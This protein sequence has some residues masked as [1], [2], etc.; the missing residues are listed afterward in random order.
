M[1]FGVPVG[2]HVLHVEADI[3]DIGVISQRPY[4]FIREGADPKAFESVTKFKKERNLDTLTQVKYKSPIGIDVRPFWGDDEQCEVGI[5]REDVDLQYNV[6]P[7]AIFMGSIF[8]NNEKD[9]VSRRCTPR[10]DVGRMCETVSTEGTVEMIRKTPS[11]GIERFDV[12]G[13]RVITENG[14]WAYQVPMNLDYVV[15]DEFGNIVPSDDPNKGIPTRARVR[16]RI[17]M[18]VT[19]GEGRLRTRAK[20][21]VPHNPNN[22]ADQDYSFDE[23]TDDNHFRDLYWNKIY[24]VRNYIARFQPVRGDDIRRMIG[25][26]DVDDCGDKTP[27]PYNRADTDAN[28]L[29]SI[30][31]ILLT[32]ITTLVSVINGTLVVV[33]NLVITAI[34][35]VFSVIANA[36]CPI[37]SGIRSALNGLTFGAVSNLSTSECKAW[38]DNSIQFV[39]CITVKCDGGNGEETYAPGCGGSSK[40]WEAARDRGNQPNHYANLLG[41]SNCGHDGHDTFGAGFIDCI[42]IRIAEAL[43]IFEFDFYNDWVNGTLFAFLLKYKKRKSGKEKWCE[44]D[45]DDF[46]GS[47]DGNNNGRADNRCKR[48]YLVDTCVKDVTLLNDSIGETLLDINGSNPDFSGEITQQIKD[49]LIKRVEEDFGGGLKVVHLYYAAM[50]HNGD[51]RLYPTDISHLGSVFDCDWQGIPRMYDLLVNTTYNRPSLTSDYGED[52]NGAQIK[53]ECGIVGKNKVGDGLFFD[54]S[55]AGLS[56]VDNGC[57]N[58]KRVSEYGVLLEDTDDGVDCIIT[59]GDIDDGAGAFFRNTFY[60]LNINGISKTSYT[61]PSTDAYKFTSPEYAAFR[62]VK[63]SMLQ[64]IGNSFY[65]YFGIT[66]GGT[67]LD[68]MNSKYF[69]DCTPVKESDFV[70]IS[71][72]TAVTSVGGSDGTITLDVVGG[73]GPFTYTVTGPTTIPDGTITATSGQFIE[74]FNS[75]SAGTYNFTIQDALGFTEEVTIIVDGPI[76]L[77]CSIDTINATTVGG[78]GTL[79]LSAIGGTP[80]G[81]NYG[82]V[83]EKASVVISTGTFTGSLNLSVPTDDINP[84]T[85]TITDGT[86]T[87]VDTG[88]IS[89]PKPMNVTV[90]KID[91]TCENNNDGEL[92]INISDGTAPYTIQVTYP[93]GS[94]NSLLNQTALEPGVYTIDVTDSAGDTFSSTETIVAAVNPSISDNGSYV[95]YINTDGS[96]PSSTTFKLRINNFLSS[97]APYTVK[98]VENATQ[99]GTDTMNSTTATFSKTFGAGIYQITVYDVNGCESNSV[100]INTTPGAASTSSSTAITPSTKLDINASTVTV[101]TIVINGV[102]GSGGYTYSINGGPFTANTIY[103]GLASATSYTFRVKDSNGCEATKVITTL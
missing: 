98:Y 82:Y 4:D 56:T 73:Q 101:D 60:A 49:G 39:P 92:S 76:A 55:C 53:T 26:K 88:L 95:C 28:P 37:I 100:V 96:D 44:Y 19:G 13:G 94:T 34:K 24:T 46:A 58:I 65:F 6:K 54:I 40:G 64:P 83:I 69:V 15:T 11:G 51:Y 9:A 52:E 86:D 80:T 42:A 78:N 103:S 45:C 20:Y 21:L 48:N 93:N 16:F 74:T 17:G 75:L 57:N 23:S 68:L 41:N 33:I 14:S 35:A 3:S 79:V 43:N 25:I 72:S 10:K 38:F 84:Y 66:P 102:G 62:N 32:I 89:G 61:A 87:C 97:R 12:E 31:C 18:D 8:S 29:F 2:Q 5:T 50:T 77:A 7:N 30:L 91:E 59:D 1:L 90:T 67:A 22:F 47:F 85:V 71:N 36:L 27:F 70:V 99:V 81:G 63:N